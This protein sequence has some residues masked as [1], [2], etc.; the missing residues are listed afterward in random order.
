M[1]STSS[2]VLIVGLVGGTLWE[3]LGGVTWIEG[4]SLGAIPCLSLSVSV[5]VSL[6]LSLCLFLC[7]SV[8]VAAAS[9]YIPLLLSLSAL[10]FLCQNV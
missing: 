5:S 8:S 6:S 10:W 3:G 2:Y 1:A 9:G 7:L 4:V